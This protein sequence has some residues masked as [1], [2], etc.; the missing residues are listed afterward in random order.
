L[1]GGEGAEE[2]KIEEREETGNLS[3][4]G[5]TGSPGEGAE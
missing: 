2:E 4:R 5:E 3:E 1:Q